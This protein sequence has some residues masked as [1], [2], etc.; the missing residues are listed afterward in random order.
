MGPP[1]Y[2]L[3][4]NPAY[5]SGSGFKSPPKVNRFFLTPY[6]ANPF[7]SFLVKL[8]TDRQTYRQTS[9]ETYTHTYKDENITS[10]GGGKQHVLTQPCFR[11]GRDESGHGPDQHQN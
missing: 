4:T 6:H 11:R 9:R 10:N 7:S 3:E 2:E 1:F 5:E 8:F